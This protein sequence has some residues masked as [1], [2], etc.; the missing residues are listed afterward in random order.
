MEEHQ[1]RLVARGLRDGN[2]DAWRALYDAHAAAVWRAVARLV[3][4]DPADVADVVQETF[5]AAARSARTYDPARGPLWAWLWGVART[6]V[7]LHWRKRRRY[8]EVLACANGRLRR[9]LDDPPPDDAA[10]RSEMA[11]VVRATLAD[12][13][14]DYESLLT[15]KYLDGAS[16]EQIADRDRSTPVAVRSK[17]ARARDAFRDAWGRRT[18]GTP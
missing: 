9:C 1:E 5:L 13:P 16:V 3:G 18:G 4:P 12:L 8:D 10:A 17:L 14:A 7:A 15:A 2:P 11:E 6:Q